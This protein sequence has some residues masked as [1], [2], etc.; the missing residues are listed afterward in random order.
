MQAALAD[1]K[2]SNRLIRTSKLIAAGVSNSNRT[3]KKRPVSIAPETLRPPCPAGAAVRRP[4]LARHSVQSALTV[5]RPELLYDANRTRRPHRRR[6]QPA[7]LRQSTRRFPAQG[8]RRVILARVCVAR[9]PL[10]SPQRE[11]SSRARP[12]P[13][14][15]RRVASP[16]MRAR[17]S[18]AR[19]PAISGR[20]RLSRAR[21]RA[22]SDTTEN[23]DAEIA[24][25][26]RPAARRAR[27]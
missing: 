10:G 1:T 14:A 12:A 7:R 11:L 19:L 24:H 4:R 15:D 6:P 9:R 3:R 8:S 18:T 26:R 13:S 20:D 5:P 23:V 22:V 25:D 21:G 2:P 16:S 17:D 27:Q